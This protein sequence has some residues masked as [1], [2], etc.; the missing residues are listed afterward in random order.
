ML[1]LEPTVEN[2]NGNCAKIFG[3]GFVIG[4]N[5]SHCA[6][7]FTEPEVE[8]ERLFPPSGGIYTERERNREK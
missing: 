8:E 1:E 7:L 2:I 5:N 6:C 4:F 3:P